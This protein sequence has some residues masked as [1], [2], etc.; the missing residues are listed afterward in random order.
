MIYTWVF[1]MKARKSEVSRDSVTGVPS[2]NVTEYL[3]AAD[4]RNAGQYFCLGVKNLTVFQTSSERME[5][6]ID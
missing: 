4:A 6:L 2:W 5:D 3:P 1:T